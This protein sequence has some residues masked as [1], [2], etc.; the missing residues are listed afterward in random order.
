[1]HGGVTVDVMGWPCGLL[2]NGA[3]L[4]E[5][6]LLG[7]AVLAEEHL[8]A[9]MWCRLCLQSLPLWC[10]ASLPQ[11]PTAQSEGGWGAGQ[12]HGVREPQPQP[13]W[14]PGLQ[15]QSRWVNTHTHRPTMR[16]ACACDVLQA[17]SGQ[18]TN[19]HCQSLLWLSVLS[20]TRATVLLAHMTGWPT[21]A[22]PMFLPSTICCML[23]GHFHCQV[24]E[25]RWLYH[26]FPVAAVV[27][28]Q[29]CWRCVWMAC[30]IVQLGHWSYLLMGERPSFD[31][32]G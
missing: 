2:G 31:P 27:G 7:G 6:H 32:A 28:L 22:P 21:V 10:V 25:G 19:L 20:L 15:Q 26:P 24:P 9:L 1:M 3:V 13:G 14:I 12:A 29:V 8:W 4:A 5:G 23:V 17:A 30:G 16:Q 11:G 18:A